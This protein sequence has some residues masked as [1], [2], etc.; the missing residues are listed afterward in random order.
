MLKTRGFTAAQHMKT[1][2]DDFAQAIKSW[3]LWSRF[4]RH[5]LMLRYRRS[6]VGPLWIVLTASVFVL[7]LTV[8]YG[9][10]FKVDI[11]DYLPFVA[12]GIALWS[13]IAAVASEGTTT[14]I[15]A[16]TYMRQMRVNVF[17]F[18]FRVVWRNVLVFG[19]QIVVALVVVLICGKIKIAMIPL[20]ILGLGLLLAQ[21]IWFTTLLG[22]FG[23]RFRDLQPIIL[24][25]LQIFFFITPVMWRPD[26]LGE[27]RWISDWNPL[28][29]SYCHSARAAARASAVSA[30]FRGYHFHN[31]RWLRHSH[32]DLRAVA[33]PA[34][35]LAVEMA[36]VELKN[37]C[38]DFPLLRSEQRSFKRLLSTP[39][40]S[41]RFG[42]DTRDRVVLHAI[43][44]MNL[45]LQDGDRLA[46]IGANGAG[47]STLLRVITGV[48]PPTFGSVTV[49]GKVGAL[50]TTGLGMRDDVSGYEN[51]E[52]CLLLQSV[53][54]ER[55]RALTDEI[56]EFTE[57]GEYLDLHV[58][59]Y[60][61]G[62]RLRLA[63]AIS[64][65]INPEILVVDEIFAA[66]DALFLKKAEKRMAALI[67]HSSILVFASHSIELLQRFCTEAIWIEGGGAREIGPIKEVYASYAAAT[68]TQ[69]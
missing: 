1:A 18:V 37:V 47:K 4:A 66:G 55:I 7:A 19:H 24:N 25:A 16:E 11:G 5:D 64:T 3:R 57:L 44:N 10:L 22:I 30:G 14:F 31:H 20:A 34:G 17:V 56:A 61:A 42:N 9:T 50:L 23:A 49:Q 58:G 38:V 28:Q 29:K 65:A 51:I 39:I 68:G 59:A 8:V 41:S 26:W 60:S 36:Y 35:L 21:S 63:F 54:A 48:Y 13:F 53:P 27:R 33:E 62:M 12:V 52:F 45:Q 43:R 15:E 6:W 46:V 67:A 2:C 40:K 69:I 32:V